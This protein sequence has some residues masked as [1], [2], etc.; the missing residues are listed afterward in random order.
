MRNSLDNVAHDLRT[1]I[2]R[3]RVTAEAALQS[4]SEP[5]AYREA[6]SD[7][8]DETETILAM[9]DTLMD[10]SE[11]ESG[12]MKLNFDNIPVK[13]LL[14]DT[15]DLYE[16]VAEDKGLRVNLDCRESLIVKGD[17]NRMRQ[18]LANLLDN[19]I[20][21]TDSGGT[22][23]L[24]AQQSDH[25]IVIVIRDTGI[26]ILPNELPHIWDRLYRSDQSRSQR[27]IGLGLSLVRAIVEAHNGRVESSSEIR[28]GS[29]FRIYLP[30][31]ESSPSES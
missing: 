20:K 16:H 18:A 13:K 30:A 3:L 8:L 27:G 21:Y 15:I 19:A 7:C 9:L 4:Q 26:G 10:I 2:T 24:E 28:K 22:I 5:E 1:P 23:L 29:S 25:E 31:G 12:S 14:E 17:R 11:A 6:L